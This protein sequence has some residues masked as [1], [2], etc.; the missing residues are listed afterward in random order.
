[1]LSHVIIYKT[2]QK[3]YWLEIIGETCVQKSGWCDMFC[4]GLS[5]KGTKG[6]ESIKCIAAYIESFPC[7]KSAGIQ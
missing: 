4:C 6:L 3:K 1:V 7:G 2:Q 5:L